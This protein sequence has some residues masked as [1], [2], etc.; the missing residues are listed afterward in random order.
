MIHINYYR[1]SIDIRLI[2]LIG[3]D[4]ILCRVYFYKDINDLSRLLWVYQGKIDWGGWYIMH[5]SL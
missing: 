4:V 5:N 3:K 1:K 2:T